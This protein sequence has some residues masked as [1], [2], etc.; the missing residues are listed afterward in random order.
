MN[1]KEDEYQ[2]RSKETK[3]RPKET[4]RENKQYQTEK[5]KDHNQT[6]PPPISTETP[7]YQFT[8]SITITSSPTI[9]QHLQ[10]R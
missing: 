10:K 5:G 7:R 8:L 2:R 6:S 1:T 3:R 4:K 9:L